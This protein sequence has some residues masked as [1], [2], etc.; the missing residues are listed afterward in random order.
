MSRSWPVSEPAQRD[1][2]RLRCA[3]IVEGRLPDD[4]V[5]ARFA[6]RGLAGVIAWPDAEPVFWAE[7]AG[8]ARQ[9]WTPYADPRVGALAGAYRLLLDGAEHHK[10]AMAATGG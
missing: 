10:S 6:R 5:A 3:V 7:L 2:E 8:A 4:L 1:Y 9:A